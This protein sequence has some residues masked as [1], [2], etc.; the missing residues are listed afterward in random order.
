MKV[1]KWRDR[2]GRGIGLDYTAME[3]STSQSGT[4]LP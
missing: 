2:A 3:R 1:S 4:M